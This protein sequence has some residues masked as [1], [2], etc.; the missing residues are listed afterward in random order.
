MARDA[1]ASDTPAR[2]ATSSSVTAPRFAPMVLIFACLRSCSERR[3]PV[4]VPAALAVRSNVLESAFRSL[5]KRF[6][7]QIPQTEEDGWTPSAS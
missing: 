5:G 7:R 4:D 1:V 6:P 3:T 2:L